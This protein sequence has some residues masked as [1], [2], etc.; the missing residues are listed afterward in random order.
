[1]KKSKRYIAN[2]EKVEKIIKEHGRLVFKARAI[3][4]LAEI[5]QIK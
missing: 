4:K 2:A 3:Q 1:M 5:E